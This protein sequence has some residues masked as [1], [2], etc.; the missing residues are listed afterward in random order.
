MP[1]IS[2]EL[3]SAM[4]GFL[5]MLIIFAFINYIIT[6]YAIYSISKVEK[7]D[8]PWLGWIPIGNFY[9]LIKLGKGSYFFIIAA[10]GIAVF[11]VVPGII[12]NI[13]VI[14][15]SIIYTVYSMYMYYKVCDR[16]DINFI[17]IAIGSLSILCIVFKS[18]GNLL[19]PVLLVGLY[20]QWNLARKVK[21]PRDF[22][23]R[24]IKTE[25]LGRQK[26]K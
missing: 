11:K 1:E 15:S 3:Q 26:T 19:I 8:R 18:L 21:K 6:G 17:F 7:V 4:L 9:Q 24:A 14:I 25:V 2:V 13:I 12:P 23:K 20:G 16:Y 22:S 10:V 5:I